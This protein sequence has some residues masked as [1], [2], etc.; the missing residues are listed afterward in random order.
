MSPRPTSNAGPRTARS[1]SSRARCAAARTTCSASRCGRCCATGSAQ[2]PGRSD[3][4]LHAMAQRRAVAPARPEPLPVRDA[5]SDRCGRRR[6]RQG[7]RRRTL[8]RAGDDRRSA[9]ALRRRPRRSRRPGARDVNEPQSLAPL[10]AACVAG[11]AARRLRGDEPAQRRRLQLRRLAGRARS[12]A[13]TH[14][15]D[16]RRSRRAPTQTAR[17]RTLRA[18]RWP[19]PASRPLPTVRCPTCW[20]RSARATTLSDVQPLWD[21]PLWW[22]GGFGYRRHGPWMGSRW[23]LSATYAPPRYEREVAVLIR[24][25]ASGKPLYESRASSEGNSRLSGRVLAAMFEAALVDFPQVGVNPRRVVVAMPDDG[26]DGADRRGAGASPRVS[27]RRRQRPQVVL[28]A[29]E[30]LA[31]RACAAP[32]SSR[33]AAARQFAV[34]VGQA[35]LVGAVDRVGETSRARRSVRSAAMR[36][37]RSARSATAGAAPAAC[38]AGAARVRRAASGS[39]GDAATPA[40]ISLLCVVEAAVERLGAFATRLTAA[41][42]RSPASGCR[43]SSRKSSLLFA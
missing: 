25:R 10:A 14:S 1:R 43:W 24:D 4:M 32:A 42:D 19:R 6:R 13:A 38:R 3:N 37:S 26:A 12:P 22:R 29:L 9:A 27:R 16:C 23:G 31:A 8:C 34:V 30:R 11:A 18:T 41:R 39:N 40:A 15:N 2:Y 20:C 5:P 21:D 17:S 7:L 33:C 36:W 28:P 35:S